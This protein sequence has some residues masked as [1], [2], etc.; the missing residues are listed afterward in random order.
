MISLDITA[1]SILT[2][3]D[4][5]KKTIKELLQAHYPD[6]LLEKA[7]YEP[8]EMRLYTWFRFNFDVDEQLTGIPM[9]LPISEFFGKAVTQAPENIG[10]PWIQPKPWSRYMDETFVIFKPS[11]IEEIQNNLKHIQRHQLHYGVR[12][13]WRAGIPEQAG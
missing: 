8:L 4:L 1:L 3:L 5:V 13:Q 9:G 7:I 6:N 11:N 10:L 12:E 2:E